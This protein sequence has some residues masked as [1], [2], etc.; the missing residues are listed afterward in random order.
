MLKISTKIYPPPIMVSVLNRIIL[1]KAIAEHTY[2]HTPLV[3]IE[4]FLYNRILSYL[5]L[6]PCKTNK[7]IHFLVSQIS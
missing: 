7:F 2:T 4:N 3:H 5:T 1:K 6:L